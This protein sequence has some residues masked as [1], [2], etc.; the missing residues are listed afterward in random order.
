MNLHK[1][2]DMIPRSLSHQIEQMITWFPVVS[3][4]GPRQ[5][6]KS[7]LLRNMFPD[8]GYANLED[9]STR[10]LATEDPTGFIRRNPRP[11]II[12]EA[13]YA[14]DLFSQIQ[15]ASDEKNTPGQ[16]ILSGSQNFLL[17]KRIEQSLAGRVGILQLLP[18]SYPEASDDGT[19]IPTDSFMFRGGYPRLY[20]ASIPP[21]VYFRNYVST[22]VQRDVA[23]Y[24]SVKN[25][26]AFRIFLRLC[27]QSAGS[28]L[29]LS[30][31]ASEADISFNTAKAWLSILQESYI[32]FLLHPFSSN[33]RKRLT[34][35]PKLYFYDSGLLSYLLELDAEEDL[36]K[37]DLRGPVF[38]NLII[39]ETL[40]SYYNKNEEPRLCFYRDT[41]GVE[42]DLVDRS[43]R[44][45]TR[46]IEIKSGLTAR[47]NF[48]DN[49]TTVGTELKIPATQRS[50]VYRGAEDISTKAGRF[51][52]A[53]TFLR[54]L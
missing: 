25:L 6:G 45:E 9:Q 27:A 34:K 43:T 13:Q 12:D 24:L 7:T 4:V 53:A 51:S 47:R 52:T 21:N 31:L 18:L 44:D 8:Y 5:S 16:Y 15:I 26:A 2:M 39:S 19:T 48:F 33:A 29:N 50:V 11:L 41:N 49:L 54:K 37:S 28:L 1:E 35:T 42:V 32:V 10:L 14:P 38:E 46:L 30:H 36:I 17:E 20:D 23:D 22:Y 40:K 3:V